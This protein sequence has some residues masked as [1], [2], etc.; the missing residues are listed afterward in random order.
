MTPSDLIE[1]NRLSAA[2]L[3]S[4]IGIRFLERT[5]E[6]V[7]SRMRAGSHLMAPNGRVHGAALVALADTTCGNGTILEI[8]GRS[9]DFATIELSA[10]FLQAPTGDE[11]E[12]VARLVHRGSTLHHWEAEVRSEG[13]VCALFRCTQ[14]VLA[15]RAGQEERAEG[16]SPEGERRYRYLTLDVFT[17][18]RFGGNPLAVFPDAA[19][20]T[21]E[22]MQTIT[23]E[24]DY[25][26]SIFL[27]R[28]E[29]AAGVPRWA[30]RIF[31]PGA[32]VPFAG[33]PTVGGA[34]ALR[35]LGEVPTGGVLVF[36]EV[37]G[38]VPVRLEPS[39]STASDRGRERAIFQVPL[40]PIFGPDPGRSL[41]ELASVI[42]LEASELLPDSPPRAIESGLRM[43]VVHAASAEAVG[44]A[45]L[46]R[47]RWRQV[48]AEEWG[49][50]LY[51][52]SPPDHEGGVKVRFFAPGFGVEEDP[53]TGSAASALGFLL[54]Q[55]ALGGP[56]ADLR[57]LL[58]Q[59]REL[60]RPSRIEVGARIREGQIETIEVGG[61][62]EVVM[63]GA[64]TL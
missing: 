34:L 47:E 23:R 22:E 26:E 36:D 6:R 45:R 11:L 60:G 30:T 57:W 61:T 24:F 10:Q 43:T 5:P 33:H 55:S 64:L 32:E 39:S 27:F 4:L 44:R 19:G 1:L 9:D 7:R 62:A 48:L 31:T 25:S 20:L 2:G 56:D 18:R 16:R 17:D 14:I 59:G 54:A 37:A 38:E 51:L 46:D 12:C 41:A 8:G 35:H 3:P 21:D 63:E 15:V 50:Q 58:D 49:H 40:L 29:A 42:G 52:V 13:R 53:A 28:R